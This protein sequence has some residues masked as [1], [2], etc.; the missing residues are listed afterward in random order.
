MKSEWHR[1]LQVLASALL[2]SVMGQARAGL[3]NDIPS[4]YAANHMQ[5]ATAA[6]ERELFVLI[7]QTTLLD[8]H[9]RAS[10]LEN[11]Q[12][13]VQP[14]SAFVVGDFS[15]FSQGHYMEILNAG[16]LELPIP[17]RDRDSIGVKVLR[18]FD[19]CMQG[20]L[21][22]GQKLALDAA[23]RAMAGSTS[24][25]AR[26]DILASVKE[27]AERVRQSSAKKKTVFLVSDML[28]NS[29]ISSFY[30]SG[31]VRV[32]DAEKELKRIEAA[33]MFA[34]FGG[35]RVFVMGAGI[36]AEPTNTK[37]RGVYRDP[38]A[39]N[40]LKSF[41]QNWFELSGAEVAEFGMPAL[42]TPVN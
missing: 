13:F 10:V 22:F 9:L 3:Q 17:A 24:T 20:Q 5:A 34:D 14:G 15:A 32:I 18:N 12:R 37:G 8:E 4:C 27:L 25:L 35:A 33:R 41:W 26:S 30:A 42:I 36:V 23:N 16:R 7:D 28:E 21:A 29:S 6:P 39:M 2:V 31:N 19:A 1:G 11:I 38:K 40:A